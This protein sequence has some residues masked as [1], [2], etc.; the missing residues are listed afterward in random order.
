MRSLLLLLL[1]AT[2]A[3]AQTTV[4]MFYVDGVLVQCGPGGCCPPGGCGPMWGDVYPDQYRPQ[5]GGGERPAPDGIETPPV[6]SPGTPEFAPCPPNSTPPPLV[7]PKMD[8]PAVPAKPCD[9]EAK[10]ESIKI[11]LAKRDELIAKL[12]ADLA[13][14]NA[15]LNTVNQNVSVMQ[16]APTPAPDVDAI[17]SEV[18]GKLTHSAEWVRLDG[19]IEKQ[20][21]PL[22]QPLKFQSER[23]GVR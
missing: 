20:T 18:A 4:P 13:A 12:Q 8:P 5:Y 22:N 23:V 17:A 19:K 3:T 2:T 14:Q 21:R 16:S 7:P 11:E 15:A 10:W 6:G 1:L 9:C